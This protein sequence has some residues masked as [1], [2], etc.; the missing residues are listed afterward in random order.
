M[1]LNTRPKPFSLT[2]DNTQHAISDNEF[3]L[4][5]FSIE[6]IDSHMRSVTCHIGIF[7]SLNAVECFF[8]HAT[9]HANHLLAVGDATELALKNKGYK[10]IHLPEEYSSEGLLKMP[11][12]QDLSG[13]S[14][15]IV[16]GENTKTLL[17]ETLTERGAHT[18]PVI[19]YRRVPIQHN[20]KKI[21]P[22]LEKN[23][24]D[25]VVSASFE[26]LEQ[27]MLLFKKPKH[28][29]WLLD[30]KLLVLTEKMRT[31]AIKLGF[32]KVEVGI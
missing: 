13:K 19:C 10:N 27:L 16:C 1:I 11:L 30:K 8:N 28:R 21:F 4:P 22:A 24:I 25:S 17:Q 9:I 5:V 20:M 31:E 3:S 12:L 26:S 23:S 2:R 14:V 18:I 32:Q 6:P 15:T 7:V 29:A